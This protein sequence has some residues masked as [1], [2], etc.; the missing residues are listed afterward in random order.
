MESA[1]IGLGSNLGE[2][3][4][5]LKQAA[6]RLRAVS[7]VI[8]RSI[9]SIRETMPVGDPSREFLGGPYL[10]AAV[11]IL[12]SLPPRFLLLECLAIESDLGRIRTKP[13]AP[14]I[15]DLDLLLYGDLVIEEPGLVIPHPRLL[16]REF[17]LEPL[18]ELAPKR[19]H[20][21]TGRTILNHY[22]ELKSQH[23]GGG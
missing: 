23:G 4:R 1:L 2:R 15:I 6:E 9:S 18:V 11:E 10:N 13:N 12:T 8:W 22:E 5:N 3:A 16:E 17:V 20:P 7:G 21:I 14:R 19:C